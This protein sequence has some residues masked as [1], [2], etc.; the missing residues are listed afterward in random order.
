M[1]RLISPHLTHE[2]IHVGSPGPATWFFSGVGFL[3]TLVLPS[4]YGLRY[5]GAQP[6]VSAWMSFY[7]PF[8]WVGVHVGLWVEALFDFALIM[9]AT[10]WIVVVTWAIVRIFVKPLL[11]LWQL[12]GV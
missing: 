9:G 4:L 8:S 7:A 12:L 11:R 3:G 1:P 10:F 5:S 6:L 2:R